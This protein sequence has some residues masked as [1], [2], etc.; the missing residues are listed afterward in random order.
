MALTEWSIEF[1]GYIETHTD[2]IVMT[3]GVVTKRAIKNLITKLEKM[4]KDYPDP[5]NAQ[6]GV[7]PDADTAP[8]R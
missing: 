3:R 5:D 4:S 6:P 1:Q 2:A 7:A 8:R